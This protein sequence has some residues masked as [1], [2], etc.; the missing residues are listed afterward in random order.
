MNDKRKIYVVAKGLH[1]WDLAA[2][3]G[4][5][6]FL[7]TAPIG[8]TGISNMTRL[9]A[10]VLANSQ[11]DDYILITGLSVM[12]SIACTLFALRHKRLNLMMFDAASEKY[13]KRSIILDDLSQVEQEINEVTR[14]TP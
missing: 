2:E 10:P 4:E 12:C 14:Y 11:P 1:S 5:L 7:S 3:Y 6:I 13:I 8:R 9:F